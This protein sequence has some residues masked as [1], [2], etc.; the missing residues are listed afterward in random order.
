M[1]KSEIKPIAANE[2]V[3]MVASIESQGH[4]LY[5]SLALFDN[6]RIFRQLKKDE[7]LLL[8]QTAEFL[9]ALKQLTVYCKAVNDVETLAKIR[10]VL[11][12]CRDR[13]FNGEFRGHPQKTFMAMNE[14]MEERLAELLAMLE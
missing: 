7:P 11:I 8:Q 13:P 6:S 12:F 1:T 10:D 3:K 2:F 14:R 4:L 5:R 9:P